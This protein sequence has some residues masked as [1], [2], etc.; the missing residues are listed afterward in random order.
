MSGWNRYERTF[1]ETYKESVYAAEIKGKMSAIKILLLA[2]F[3][4]ITSNP[5][6]NGKLCGQSVGNYG[7]VESE[8][9]LR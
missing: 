6:Q 4:L 8:N 3:G 5:L 7:I 2:I 9:I 1:V